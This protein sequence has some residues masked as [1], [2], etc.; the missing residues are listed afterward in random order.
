MDYFN[1]E[2]MEPLF[3]MLEK[4]RG[5][6]QNP[7]YHPEVEVFNHSL[8]TM[9]WA[10]KEA[11]NIDLVFAAMLHDVGKA[12]NPYGHDVIGAELLKPHVS[13]KTMWFVRNHLRGWYY[14]S[15]EMRKHQKSIDLGNHPW[16]PEL[17]QLC[18]WDK[19][20]RNPYINPTYNKDAILVQFNKK[21]DEYF[22]APTSH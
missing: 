10:F 1:E 11:Q 19:M 2:Y 16:F 7:E 5:V 6:T 3:E 8:Q 18:R 4:T 12:V 14:V 20:G 13:V 15:G 21:A 17:M 22:K 9:N